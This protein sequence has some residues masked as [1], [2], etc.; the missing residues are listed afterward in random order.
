M[1]N[2]C[3]KITKDLLYTIDDWVKSHITTNYTIKPIEGDAGARKYWRI[4]TTTTSY[5]LMHDPSCSNLKRYIAYNK[6]FAKYNIKTPKMKAYDLQKQL[7]LQEDFGDQLLI[8]KTSGTEKELYYKKSIFEIIK[9]QQ[10]PHKTTIWDNYCYT[11]L[12]D[13]MNLAPEWYCNHHLKAPLSPSNMAL[14]A[15]ICHDIASKISNL[16]TTLVHRDFHSRNLLITGAGSLGVID[17]QDALIGP[18]S[19][20]LSSLLRDYYCPLSPELL[21]KLQI[22]YLNNAISAGIVK[23]DQ[24]EFNNMFQLTALQ[25]HLKVL[26]I[27]CRLYYRDSKKQYLPYLPTVAIYI[28]DAIAELH[29]YPEYNALYELL[30]LQAATKNAE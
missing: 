25:R 13:E 14:F 18:V 23:L 26:G 15:D 3:Q 8:T 20:D 12:T 11:K 4:T 6:E 17:F 27:F 1:I 22:F 21:Q 30:P 28:K 29:Q 5:I 7:L 2:L 10:I 16:P 9:L 24:A 19:Y